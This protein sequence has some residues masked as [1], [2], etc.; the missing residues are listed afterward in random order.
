MRDIHRSII[1]KKTNGTIN[2][3]MSVKVGFR[4]RHHACRE[5]PTSQTSQY[6]IRRTTTCP[7]QS[8]LTIYFDIEFVYGYLRYA[9]KMSP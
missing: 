2:K 6:E 1:R 8:K 9:S 4:R 7:L 3:F 5:S